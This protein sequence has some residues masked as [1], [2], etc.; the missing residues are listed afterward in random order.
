[1]DKNKSFPV[2]RTLRLPSVYLKIFY[3]GSYVMG[4]AAVI[5]ALYS[6]FAG[7]GSVLLGLGVVLMVLAVIWNVVVRFMSTGNFGL[8]KISFTAEYILFDTGKKKYRLHWRD[9]VCV[10]VEKTR[11]AY[12]VYASDHELDGSER[13]E[14][15]ENVRE[16]V[17][18]FGYAEDAWEEFV[19]F[20]PEELRSGLKKPM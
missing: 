7:D 3:Y 15:P 12:W 13:R 18:Y 11:R 19:K 5:M 17:F 4:A 6:L 10:G 20:V 14:F 16:G 9:V 8:A 2:T 1:M